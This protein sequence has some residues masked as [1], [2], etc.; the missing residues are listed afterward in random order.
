MLFQA[1]FAL[2]SVCTSHLLVTK[3]CD[4]KE[5]ISEDNRGRSSIYYRML[6]GL[7]NGFNQR[8]SYLVRA[9]QGGSELSQWFERH[10]ELEWDEFLGI[11][12]NHYQLENYGQMLNYGKDPIRWSY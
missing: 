11:L 10:P 8:K 3:I 2:S 9:M 6:E 1:F 4:T 7:N 5:N 12:R